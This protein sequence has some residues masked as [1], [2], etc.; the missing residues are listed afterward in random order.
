MSDSDSDVP[1]D[2]VIGK[3]RMSTSRR[4]VEDDSDDGEQQQHAL[5]VIDGSDDEELPASDDEEQHALAALIRQQNAQPRR[6]AP[7]ARGVLSQGWAA[8]G[9]SSALA[10]PVDS[11][12][13]LPGVQKE[14]RIIGPEHVSEDDS[15]EAQRFLEKP[16]ARRKSAAGGARVAPR[17]GHVDRRR[18]LE[19]PTRPFAP[20]RT[21]TVGKDP[22][23]VSQADVLDGL[24]EPWQRHLQQL[25]WWLGFFPNEQLK[26]HQFE[27]VLRVAGVAPGDWPACDMT[28]LRTD[29]ERLAALPPPPAHRGFLLGDVMGL[30]KTWQTIGGILL[31]EYFEA[32]RGD[33]GL[34]Q[35]ADR[36]TLIIAPNCALKDMWAGCLE[37]CGVHKSEILEYEGAAAEK[38]R[39]HGRSRMGVEGKTV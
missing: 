24:H 29:E 33:A 22:N 30:G 1:L 26:P 7:P 9:S 25:L 20:T 31:V 32:V 34:T 39:A 27:G 8:R 5:V 16:A 14:R 13:E 3:R 38:T 23:K 37:K 6:P 2:E 15:D 36:S 17:P 10:L 11:D 4:V 19:L 28:R 12:D 35:P 18:R 21:P